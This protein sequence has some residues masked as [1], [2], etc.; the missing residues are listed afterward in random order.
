M[1]G[2]NTYLEY[3]F[4]IKQ[5]ENRHAD[6]GIF[7][8]ARYLK[9]TVRPSTYLRRKSTAT[10]SQTSTLNQSAYPNQTFV[11]LKGFDELGPFLENVMDGE[12]KMGLKKKLF[13]TEIIK[14][15]TDREIG[16]IIMK[17]NDEAYADT[18]V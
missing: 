16:D 2:T 9:D 7:N 1:A 11:W 10:K 17:L 13:G 14:K 18:C 4:T 15:H 6:T 8:S 3:R 5:F 12:Y